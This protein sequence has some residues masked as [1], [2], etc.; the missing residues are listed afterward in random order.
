MSCNNP[1]IIHIVPKMDV[2]G[3][4]ETTAATLKQL[5]VHGTLVSLICFGGKMCQDLV[6]QG[7]SVST[8]PVHSKNPITQILNVFRIAKIARKEH[9]S[10][11][12][13]H[14]RAPAWSSYFAAKLA[15]CRFITTFHS[16]Y[17]HRLLKRYYSRIMT[18]GDLT[19]A[20]STALREHIIETYD[21]R[22]NQ[23][24]YLP[25]FVTLPS[26]P[27]PLGV[28]AF[29]E[30]YNIPNNTLVLTLVCRLSLWKGIDVALEALTQLSDSNLILLIVGTAK[31]NSHL[32]R[33]QDQLRRTKTTNSVR[34]LNGSRSNITHAFA[35]SA[36]A[37]SVSSSKP[38]GFGMT[39]LEALLFGLPIISSA[40][41]GVLDLVRD[42]ENGFLFEP[43]NAV[44]LASK[45]RRLLNLNPEE[46]QEMRAAAQRQ[47]VNYAPSL[48]VS[49]LQRIYAGLTS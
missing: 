22:P 44:D 18:M 9:A 47:A 39:V 48:V 15:G 41:G 36:G 28:S 46:Q 38:E 2:G 26:S 40:H 43:K 11:I 32:Q 14:S 7:I 16:Y 33:L 34:I 30:M 19:I 5:H 10:V 13:C 29:R 1:T 21:V 3:V 6:S 12:H 31:K 20:P 49:S 45:I 35:I 17:G 37:L 8:L 42:G 25:H 23:V 4:E 24:I 27:D